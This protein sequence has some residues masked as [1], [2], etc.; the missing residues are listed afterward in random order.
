MMY[1]EPDPM[2]TVTDRPYYDHTK[3]MTASKAAEK[4]EG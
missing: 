4:E 2:Q 3:R 1:K